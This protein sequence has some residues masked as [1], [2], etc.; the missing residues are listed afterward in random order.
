MANQKKKFHFRGFISFTITWTFIILAFSGIILYFS[1]KGRVANWTDWTILGLTK[2]GWSGLHTIIALLFLLAIILHIYLNWNPLLNYL[3][4]KIRKGIKLKKELILS[5]VLSGLFFFGALFELPPFQ[6]IIDMAERI[7]NYWELKSASAP[8][9]HAEDMTLSELAQL[10]GEPVDMLL[11]KLE[12][13]TIAV[14]DTNMVLGDIA[15]KYDLKPYEVYGY[16]DDQKNKQSSSSRGGSR[17]KGYGQMSIEEVCINNGITIEE[18]L[19]RLKN[20]NINA[21]AKENVRFIAVRNNLKPF[22]LVE[23]I[24]GN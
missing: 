19:S 21:E 13:H 22:E 18:G 7:D 2:E 1:P 3:R 9:P 16:F 5:V 15:E 14:S 23:I 24:K 11:R 4:D 12:K 8:V 10:R 17:G 20:Y 6:N